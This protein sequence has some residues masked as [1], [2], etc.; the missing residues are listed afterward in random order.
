MDEV[1]VG[2]IQDVLQHQFIAAVHEVHPPGEGWLRPVQ[3]QKGNVGQQRRIGMMGVAVPNP[4]MAITVNHGVIAQSVREFGRRSLVRSAWMIVIRTHDA[5]IP[6]KK[7]G[8]GMH[9]AVQRT[10]RQSRCV[11]SEEHTSELQS[12]M[13][14]SYACFCLKKKKTETKEQT[15]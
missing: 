2:E 7:I 11:R 1:G 14:I 4:D 8:L 6:P 9:R 12:L 13:R 10:V 3:G 5:V 15:T